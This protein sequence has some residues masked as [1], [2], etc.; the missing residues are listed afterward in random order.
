[1]TL[2]ILFLL[3]LFCIFCLMIVWWALFPTNHLLFFFGTTGAGLTLITVLALA[4]FDWLTSD[5]VTVNIYIQF[6]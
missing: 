1:M 6:I 3:G 4:V 2:M 5:P